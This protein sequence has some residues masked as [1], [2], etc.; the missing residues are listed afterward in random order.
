MIALWWSGGLTP[1]NQQHIDHMTLDRAFDLI[2]Q[3]LDGVINQ[4]TLV[5]ELR[6][7][8]GQ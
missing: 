8:L 1:M 6:Q 4:D 3:Y 2:R 7:I 5:A